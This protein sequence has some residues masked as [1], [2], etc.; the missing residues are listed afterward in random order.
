MPDLTQASTQASPLFPDQAP[1]AALFTRN[2]V[3]LCIG[4]FS[5]LRSMFL[6]FAILPLFVVQELHGAESQVGMIMG[7]FAIA[8]VLTRPFSGQMVSI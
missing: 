8:A 5:L 1:Q 7:A 6:L 4:R 3:L 2:Y